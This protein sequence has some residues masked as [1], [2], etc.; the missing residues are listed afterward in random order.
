MGLQMDGQMGLQ[1][2]RLKILMGWQ[3]GLQNSLKNWVEFWRIIGI[4]GL[5]RR[6]LG[7][8]WRF[9]Q[10]CFKG[11]FGVSCWL[12]VGFRNI[13]TFVCKKGKRKGKFWRKIASGCCDWYEYECYE[14][15]F[16]TVMCYFDCRSSSRVM[17]FSLS[18]I[19]RSKAEMSCF[20]TCSVGDVG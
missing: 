10:G 5:L 17:I 9:L 12:S 7:W 3:M 20:S 8:V 19:V 15:L 6:F 14:V 18:F 11:I 16:K 13:L 1:N 2:R 4:Y